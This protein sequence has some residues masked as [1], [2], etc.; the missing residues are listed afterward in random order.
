MAATPMM[1]PPS[2]TWLAADLA[3]QEPLGQDRSEADTEGEQRQHQRDDVGVGEQDV[4]GEDGQARTIV[5]PNSQ[6]HEI[7]STGTNSFGC[8]MTWLTTESE[9]ATSRGRGVSAD[10]AGGAGGIR[11][12]ASQPAV[13]HA[14]PMPP[15]TS[16]PLAIRTTLPPMMV[17]SRIDRKVPASMSA[18]LATSSSSRRCWA[19][20]RI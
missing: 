11:R 1:I 16:A 3:V 6:N 17:P 8:R 15:T 5:A 2:G 20:A 7:A 19:A 9:S 18:L 4:L 12:E 13:A 10:G 14:M